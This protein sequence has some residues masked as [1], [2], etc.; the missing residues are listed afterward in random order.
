[1]PFLH[2]WYRPYPSGIKFFP[3]SVECREFYPEYRSGRGGGGRR[4]DLTQLLL[5]N[6]CASNESW[7]GL[8][9][10]RSHHLQRPREISAAMADFG[11]QTLND[12]LTNSNANSTPGDLALQ[13]VTTAD[14]TV[15]DLF[16]QNATTADSTSGLEQLGLG[17]PGLGQLGLEQI[18]GRDFPDGSYLEWNV[19]E[20]CP[21]G[22]L[23][24]RV[25]NI[26]LGAFSCDEL[27]R[28]ANGEYGFGDILAGVWCPE[29]V[30]HLRNCP[31]GYYCP[32]SVRFSYSRLYLPVVT[33]SSFPGT[34]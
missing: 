12:L 1:M 13:N 14:S 3:P 29:N 32:D 19:S 20:P 7:R 4:R 11:D 5:R 17:Q 22:Y 26:S 24:E 33:V 16:L 21:N 31:R 2:C 8:G 25:G 34:L 23:C 10:R 28:M 27:A 6:E 15:N 18:T 9:T 30:L